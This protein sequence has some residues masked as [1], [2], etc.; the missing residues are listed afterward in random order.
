MKDMLLWQGQK[1]ENFNNYSSSDLRETMLILYL[2]MKHDYGR[3][4]QGY[5][6]EHHNFFDSLWNMGHDILYFDFMTLMQER[7]RHWMNRRLKEVVDSVKPDLLFCVLFTEELDKPVI[8]DISTNSGTATLNWFCDDH[9]RF[10]NYSRYW[11]PC[12]NWVVTTDSEAL[13][14]YASLGY[15]TAIKSQWAC[16]QFLYRRLELPLIYDATFVGQ[17]HGNRRA[18]I[19]SLQD[20]G[21]D[22]R[23]WGSGWES[24]RLSQHEMVRVFNQS[25]INLNLSNAS[26]SKETASQKERCAVY[27]L[28]SRLAEKLQAM[29]GN[30]ARWGWLN[31]MKSVIRSVRGNIR[32]GSDEMEY[33]DQIKGRNFEV[34]GCGGFLMTGL[35]DDLERYYEI[36]N[37]ISCFKDMRALT[38]KTRYFLNHQEER[39]AIAEAGYLRTLRE[40]TYMHRFNEIFRTMGLPSQAPSTISTMGEGA[41][42]MGQVEEVE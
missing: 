23:V 24:G 5:S 12:F 28:L 11:A 4:E 7:G 14:K 38:E 15:R 27:R 40:H 20:H 17:P 33:S 32:H 19:R 8:H 1:F 6:Y 39:E 22:V 35:A 16:N 41:A 34:P 37:E 9:W 26:V 31:L 36:D 21:I 18:I 3:K 42:S 30:D 29:A 10:D 25:R 13:P 2:G